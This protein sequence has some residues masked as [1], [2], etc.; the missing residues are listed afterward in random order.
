MHLL[1]MWT[2]LEVRMVHL[3]MNVLQIHEGYHNLYMRKPT[4]TYFTFRETS[5]AEFKM[6]FV[7]EVD[8]CVS[9]PT[10]FGMAA[11]PA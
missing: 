10:R 7:R 1:W 5:L 6:L 2:A 8:F 3:N 11:N 9:S 4:V